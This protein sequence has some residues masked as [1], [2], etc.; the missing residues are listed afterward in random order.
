MIAI[1]DHVHK[2]ISVLEP[3]TEASERCT[4]YTD[5]AILTE[6]ESE[7]YSYS[8]RNRSYDSCTDSD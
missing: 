3:E 8:S 7:H 6:S 2:N 4:D 5:E 1:L